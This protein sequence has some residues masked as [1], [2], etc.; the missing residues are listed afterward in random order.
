M[1]RWAGRKSREQNR[2]EPMSHLYKAK[3]KPSDL[4]GFPGERLKGLEPS[5]FCMAS[6][7]SSQLSYSR[8]GEEYNPGAGGRGVDSGAVRPGAECS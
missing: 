2:A 4:E 8:E 6:R 3:E 5:T 7:R 1:L